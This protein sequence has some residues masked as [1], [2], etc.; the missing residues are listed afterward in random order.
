MRSRFLFSY[1]LSWTNGPVRNNRPRMAVNPLLEARAKTVAISVCGSI[2]NGDTCWTEPTWRHRTARKSWLYPTETSSCCW[3]WKQANTSISLWREAH[4]TGKR[5]WIAV[6][7]IRTANCSCHVSFPP[8]NLYFWMSEMIS[9]CW[10]TS[11]QFYIVSLK[12]LWVG[13]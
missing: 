6:F 2:T 10:V 3:V 11:V 9:L 12:V 13:Y 5:A 1:F 4:A 7:R 8:Q